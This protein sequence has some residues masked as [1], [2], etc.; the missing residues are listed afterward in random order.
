MI[1]KISQLIKCESFSGKLLIFSVIIALIISNTGIY[2]YYLSLANMEFSLTIGAFSVEENFLYWVNNGFMS[3]FFLLLALEIKYQFVDGD[4][5]SFEKVGLSLFAAVGGALFSAFT[6]Y[7][8]N[9]NFPEYQ[10]GWA[11]PMASDSAFVLAIIAIF[12]TRIP[13]AAKIFIIGFSLIDDAISIIVLAVFYTNN[14]EVMPILI[15]F[16]IVLLLV[17][18]NILQV[19]SLKPYVILGIF[20]WASITESG[21]NSTFSGVI[22]GLIVPVKAKNCYPL[23]NLKDSITSFVFY[24]ILPCFAFLNAQV[25]IEYLTYENLSSTITLG[26][27]FGLMIG[28]P[29]GIMIATY[30]FIK[31]KILSLP[32]DTSLKLYLSLAA[33]CG[34]GFTLNLFVSSLAFYDELYRDQ[35]RIGIFIGALLS[36]IF[37]III[38]YK[39]ERTK[40]N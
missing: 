19:K 13:K 40:F 38:L 26:I 30:P 5:N 1:K 23:N 8:I 25:P 21:L 32:K 20:L 27:I 17:V 18:L 2:K 3:L 16:I 14:L 7:L 24:I 34:M 29:L 35:A 28:K 31:A 36:Y 15:S 37:G 10:S 6:Y 33:F 39:S 11:I 22:L 9:Y 4:F 12:G